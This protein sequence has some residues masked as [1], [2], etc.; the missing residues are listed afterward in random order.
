MNSNRVIKNATWIIV[1]KIVQSVLGLLIG[2]FTARYLGPSNYGIVNYATSIVAF[3]TPIVQLGFRNTLV[4]E[5]VNNPELEG[6][7]VG[8]SLTLSFISSLCCFLGVGLFVGIA[9]HGEK[10][11]IVVCL[12]YSL[13]LIFQAFEMI[14]YWYQ[15]KLLSKY[16]SVVSIIA[17]L[18]VSL[19]KIYLLVLEKSIYWFALSQALDFL[20]ISVFLL[21][22]YGKISH[23]KL[24]FSLD[25][26]KNMFAVSK[27]YILSAVMVAT[28]NHIGNIVLKFFLDESAV[29]YFS[30]AITCV[31]IT[32]FIFNAIIDSVRPSIL[33]VRQKNI[34]VYRSRIIKLYSIVIFGTVVQSV[35][36]S[37]FSNLIITVLYGRE[38]LPSVTILRVMC[39][40]A[41]FSYL[42]TIRNIWILAEGKQKYLW[43]INLCGAIFNVLMNIA[44]ISTM[45]ILGAAITV[46]ATQIFTNIVLGFLMPTIKENNRLMIK[47]FNPKYVFLLFKNIFSNGRSSL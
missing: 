4:Q 25:I 33:E 8:T 30:A 19:Y 10:E 22:I 31:N 16:T 32:G 9:N 23:R 11:T 14:Q 6:K 47:G 15:A 34:K 5:I 37:L 24:S 18:T 39:W 44:L 2:M 26:G 28:F 7:I 29:G 40:M 12:L 1:C 36:I 3:V 17:Y 46:I 27:H 41:V 42:G 13:S 20:I 43:I 21:A 35:V 38:F 45:G